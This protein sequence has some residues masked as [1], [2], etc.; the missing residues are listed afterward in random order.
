[1]L[2][3]RSWVR[4]FKDLKF[5]EYCFE[6][7]CR[8]EVHIYKWFMGTPCPTYIVV[9]SWGGQR[10]S[11]LSIHLVRYCI[12]L[13]GVSSR[14]SNWNTL[15]LVGHSMDRPANEGSCHSRVIRRGIVED[16][17]C[18]RCLNSLSQRTDEYRPPA[19]G[20]KIQLEMWVQLLECWRYEVLPIDRAP[21]SLQM[22]KQFVV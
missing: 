21:C 20:G 13:K 5:R 4:V 9:T 3:V 10:R 19:Q 1:V 14:N 2:E 18:V 12:C 7:S 15:Q 6:N 16:V 22:K 11:D 8:T 17:F